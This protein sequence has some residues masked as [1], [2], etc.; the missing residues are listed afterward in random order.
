MASVID[1][2]TITILREK[3]CS[4]KSFW[5]CTHKTMDSPIQRGIPN[6]RDIICHSS[7]YWVGD[8]SSIN[9]WTEPWILQSDYSEPG[10]SFDPLARPR[11]VM[12]KVKDL[13][14]PNSR[15]WNTN[16]LNQLVDP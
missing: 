14:L 1:G 15:D 7:C 11:V 5:D 8:D 6:T 10:A 12:K 2:L 13:F 3:Y 9:I 4:M 16:L